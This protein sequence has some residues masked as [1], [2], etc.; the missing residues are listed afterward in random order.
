MTVRE[1]A[2]RRRID[3]APGRKQR[4]EQ[5]R[6]GSHTEL[7]GGRAAHGIARG[8]ATN[9]R[10]VLCVDQLHAH[11]G[12]VARRHDGPGDQVS[13]SM[14]ERDR[15]RGAGQQARD[16]CALGGVE[17]TPSIEPHQRIGSLERAADHDRDGF[18]LAL[19]GVG[20]GDP[21]REHHDPV[22]VDRE[23]GPAPRQPQT[24][25]EEQDHD[26]DAGQHSRTD[27]ARSGRLGRVRRILVG[28]V[29]LE[30]A[31]ESLGRREAIRGR[32]RKSP[33]YDRLESFGHRWAHDANRRRRLVHLARDH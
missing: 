25:R 7:R 4:G 16:V 26:Q 28:G 21:E 2:Q 30:R 1:R 22:V 19:L 14:C 20:A 15:L 23:R 32:L 9:D 10:A 27:R 5:S 6:H 29:R 3:R 33:L 8:R 24:E 11:I 12:R 17:P 18:A 13:G 31:R